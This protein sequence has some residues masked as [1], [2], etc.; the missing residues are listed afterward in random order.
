MVQATTTP[1]SHTLV[2]YWGEGGQYG[3]FAVQHD[4]EWAGWPD[5]G[6]VLRYFR[7]QAKLSAR[8]FGE[9]YGKTVNADGSS[10]SERWILDMELVNK[11]PADIGRRKTIARL[12]TIPPMLFGLA[13]LEDMQLEPRPQIAHGAATGQSKLVRVGIDITTY[14]Q[15]IRTI[16]QLHEA[17][18]A[19]GSLE[20]VEA[21]IH[22]LESFEHQTLGDLRYQVQELLL[23]NYILATHIVRDQRQFRRAY[24]HANRAVRVARSMQETDLIATALFTRGWTRLEW[25]LFGMLEHGVFQVQ[26]ELLEA[27]IRDFQRARDLFPTQHGKESMHP[28]LLGNLIMYLSRAQLALATSKGERVPTSVLLAIDDVA[29]TVDKQPIDDPYTRVLVRGQR[30]SW[31]KASYLISRASTFS[32]AG[33]PGRAMNELNAYEKLKEQMY[34]RDETRR[35]AWFDILRANV[36]MGLEEFGTA[37]TCIKQALLTCQDINSLTNVAIITDIYGRLLK[38]RHKASRG[39]QEL[40]DILR[41]F[42]VDFLEPEE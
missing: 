2:Y 11:V 13:V 25:A 35:S 17:S 40:G 23:S 30:V 39:V 41:E 14:Q 1:A 42:P 28:Q 6:Q 12:L 31:H 5:F 4:G 18:N 3:P 34:N 7:K 37:T 21:D 27:A 16:W 32:I 24:T 33:L 8:A 38:S 20:Q 29:D 19:Q 15:H 10:I 9:L 26:Q 22:D 36:Y